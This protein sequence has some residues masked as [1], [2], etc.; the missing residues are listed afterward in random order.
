MKELLGLY[1]PIGLEI[2]DGGDRVKV[3][4]T[5]KG[6]GRILRVV[7]HLH[8]QVFEIRT[9]FLFFFF[10]LLLLDLSPSNLCLCSPI[11]ALLIVWAHSLLVV[12]SLLQ[13]VYL[14]KILHLLQIDSISSAFNFQ[15]A[16]VVPQIKQCSGRPMKKLFAKFLL[17][18]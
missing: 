8:S 2:Y 9:C 7:S 5:C 14:H 11:E 18:E 16:F 10:A 17:Y 6:G 13:D 4:G 3:E 1:C 12:P 15:V